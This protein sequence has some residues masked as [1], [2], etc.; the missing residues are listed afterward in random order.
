MKEAMGLISLIVMMPMFVVGALFWFSARTR[1]GMVFGVNVPLEYADGADVEGK[2]RRYRAAMGGVTALAVVLALPGLMRALPWLSVTA[3][4]L[5]LVAG[6][7]LWMVERRGVVGH[8]VDVPVERTASLRVVSRGGG[9]VAV[10]AAALLP[11]GAVW[12]VLRAHWAEIPLRFA[13]HWNA[14]GVVDG[15]ATRDVRSLAMP[16]VSGAL[17]VLFVLAIGTFMRFA[18]AVGRGGLLHILL[19]SLAV[20]GWALTAIF[21]VI[22]LLPLEGDAGPRLML[23]AMAG[24]MVVIFA[25]VG[26]MVWQQMAMT[27]YEVYDGTPNKGWRAGGMI[28]Y[29]PEDGAVVVPKRMGWGWTLNMAHGLAWVYLG[30]VVMVVGVLVGL[31]MWM[32]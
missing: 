25:T 23:V 21:C 5:V 29:N 4:P 26:W 31:G 24:N 32:K 18:P 2:V 6:I 20:I 28:Y 11:L 9:W 7:G 12:M 13:Q 16:L 27:G 22:A 1:R 14:Q 19:P 8:G 15:W 10:T 17:L 30:M 3:V